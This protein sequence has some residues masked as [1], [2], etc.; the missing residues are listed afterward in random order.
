MYPPF[1][2]SYKKIER[3]R[4]L[5]RIAQDILDDYRQQAVV[6][7]A[8]VRKEGE[9]IEWIFGVE[10]E[11]P[12]SIDE[13][14]SDAIHNLRSSLDIMM[15]DIAGLYR[16]NPKSV[17]FPFGQ[18]EDGFE[19][20]L[21]SRIGNLPEHVKDKVRDAKPYREN[22][23]P[24]LRGLH[25]LDIRDKHKAPI[26]V[27]TVVVAKFRL[28]IGGVDK[29]AINFV[30]DILQGAVT[31]L[32]LGSTFWAKEGIDPRAIYSI[33]PKQIDPTFYADSPF[34]KNPAI[35]LITE[36][37]DLTE[38]LVQTFAAGESTP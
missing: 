38:G 26:T 16:K 37:A 14:I 8:Q 23:T 2:G 18:D 19:N 20:I 21:R 4:H 10:N 1:H 24:W 5:A 35:P 11:P 33:D 6:T 22:G 13:N 36:L 29:P 3:A 32:P 34:P 27:L 28:R 12:S 7:C 15:V 31:R 25:D 17:V 30:N 9:S